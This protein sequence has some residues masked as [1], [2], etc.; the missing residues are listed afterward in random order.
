MALFRLCVNVPVCGS[1]A[2]YWA[3]KKEKCSAHNE[4]YQDTVNI[5]FMFVKKRI[6]RAFWEE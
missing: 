1:E 2:V 5:Q 6:W 3:K 4:R